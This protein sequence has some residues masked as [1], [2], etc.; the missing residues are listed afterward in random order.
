[1]ELKLSCTTGFPHFASRLFNLMFASFSIDRVIEVFLNLTCRSSDGKKD[2]RYRRKS[3]RATKG[4]PLY[5][6]VRV[7]DSHRTEPCPVY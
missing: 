5:A 7:L 3:V 6:Y 1:M 2:A 4:I